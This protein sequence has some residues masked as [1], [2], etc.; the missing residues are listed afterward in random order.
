MDMLQP[1]LFA[2]KKT[3][4]Q[5]TAAPRFTSKFFLATSIIF[6]SL[7]GIWSANATATQPP[8]Q[9]L[10]VE[11]VLLEG[12]NLEQQGLWG[13]AL[14]VYQSAL[15]SWPAN[16]I[17]KTRRAVARIHYDLERR[18]SDASFID[19]IHSTD[20]QTA[21]GVYS[22][23]LLKIQS[24]Y[25][26]S[27]DWA[28]LA[29]YGLTSLEV[30][31][32]TQ[33]FVDEN[34]S[35]V[36]R[37]QI[38]AEILRNRKLADQTTVNDRQ[39]AYRFANNVSRSL[40][41]NLGL[42]PQASTYEFICGA[43]SALDPY[44]AFMSSNQYSETMSQIEGNFVGLGV[45]LRTHANDLEIVSVIPGGSADTGGLIKGDR[46][47]AVDQVRVAEVGS[48]KSADMLRGIEGSYVQL[49]I[50]RGEG[51]VQLNLQR[52]RVE[53]P[54]VDGV[55]ILDSQNG[56]GYIRLTNF[57]KT[58]A[59]DFD[60][61]LW[62]LHRQG[63][64][65]LIV[66]VRGN[67]GGLLSA[68]VEIADRFV[69]S[70][71]IVTT[72]GRNTM[73][74]YT[75]RANL[76]RTWRVPLVVLVDE[77]SASASEIFAAAIRDHKRGKIVGTRSYGKGSVQ[78]IFPLNVSG[79]GVRLTTAKFYSPNGQAISEVGVQADYE[80]VQVGKYSEQNKD[81]AIDSDA[82]I[83]MGIKAARRARPLV[84]NQA[85]GQAR[86]AQGHAIAGRQTQAPQ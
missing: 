3:N 78:G 30:A 56:V 80:V 33:E 17:V 71:K 7:T 64:R 63:M 9:P 69:T 43:I 20:A 32:T 11:Q 50:D 86:P 79:G 46:I 27:P 2:T 29:S 51:P 44:S 77:N 38:Q 74:N 54:S 75:H 59:R 57:Q 12:K 40:S 18:Y 83:A 41:Q 45:E 28:D 8:V 67:P 48:E 62:K 61:A 37:E 21:M 5:R 13:E 84:L 39:D 68:S 25:V 24:Y 23:V 81:D 73:E 49:A 35:G 16:E 47:I 4:A 31:L 26:D 53:I 42:S 6:I 70:G 76:E 58:T 10:D 65:S 36:T 82:G 22:E 55:Q 14:G 34:L 15:K 1:M 72:R 52:R 19:T 60:N 66:D 85:I